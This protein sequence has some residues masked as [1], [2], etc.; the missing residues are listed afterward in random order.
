MQ[1]NCPR[2]IYSLTVHLLHFPVFALVS[3]T[4]S[5]LRRWALSCSDWAVSPASTSCPLCP[6]PPHLPAAAPPQTHASPSWLCFYLQLRAHT[7]M[8]NQLCP[9]YNE[10]HVFYLE[11]YKCHNCF[12]RSGKKMW[13]FVRCPFMASCVFPLTAEQGEHKERGGWPNLRSLN[14]QDLFT[15]NPSRTPHKMQWS[16]LHLIISCNLYLHSALI[17]LTTCVHHLRTEPLLLFLS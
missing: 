11:M 1:S 2:I 15:L 16:H 17:R 9:M 10:R 14:H 3:C 6:S 4:Q 5:H 12:G 13:N 7:N 8:T